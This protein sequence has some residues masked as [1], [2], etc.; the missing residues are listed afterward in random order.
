MFLRGGTAR[1]S[2]FTY[3]LEW[4]ARLR[5]FFARNYSP[6]APLIW[7]GDL[8]VAPEQIDVHDPKRL[9]GHVCFTPEVW[10]AFA[11]VRSWV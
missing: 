7:C 4:L 10:E 5:Q 8:N 9:L 2:I 1:R 6:T 11:A 3:K